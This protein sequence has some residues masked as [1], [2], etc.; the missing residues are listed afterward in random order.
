[1]SAFLK[2]KSYKR[3][4]TKTNYSCEKEMWFSIYFITN[5]IDGKFYVGSSKN[6]KTRWS[7]HLN[8]LKNN[9]HH[10]KYLQ[11]AWNKYG[12]ENF[13]FNV[14]NQVSNQNDLIKLEQNYLNLGFDLNKIYNSAKTAYKAKGPNISGERNPNAKLNELD[15]KSIRIK[16]LK[17]N[18]KIGDK[19]SLLAKEYN[20]SLI[21]ISRI[22]R[23]KLWINI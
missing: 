22:I 10:C 23:E 13:V 3:N 8:L 2:N 12:G 17:L 15:V 4:F 11:H 19:Y 6:Y 20:V 18:G 16:Y 7:V 21:T 1:M 9:N 14:V 5:I